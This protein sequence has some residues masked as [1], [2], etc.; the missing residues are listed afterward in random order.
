[1]P[2]SVGPKIDAVKAA[3]IAASPDE[4]R[5]IRLAVTPDAEWSTWPHAVLGLIGAMGGDGRTFMARWIRKWVNVDG[6]L[7]TAQ[8]SNYPNPILG[9]APVDPRSAVLPPDRSGS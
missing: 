8:P 1:M 5:Q 2:R 9:T 6:Q 7:T 4:R 3:I